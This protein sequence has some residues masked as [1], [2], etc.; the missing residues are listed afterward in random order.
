[1]KKRLLSILLCL[2]TVV[3]LL[4]TAAFAAGNTIAPAANTL[5]ALRDAFSKAQSGDTVQLTGDITSSSDSFNYIVINKAVT[6]DFAGFTIHFNAVG[7]GAS[8]LSGL[9]YLNNGGS[10]TLKGP[11]GAILSGNYSEFVQANTG[12]KLTVE[13]GTYSSVATTNGDL[14]IAYGAAVEIKGGALSSKSYYTLG[15]GDGSI[16][17]SGGT[18]TADGTYALVSNGTSLTMTGGTISSNADLTAYV[19]S[20]GSINMTG[21]TISNTGS[22]VA[23]AIQDTAK[24]STLSG[25][26]ITAASGFGIYSASKLT[27]ADG[28]VIT[29]VSGG[30]LRSDGTLT[31]TGGS[32]SSD[33]GIALVNGGSMSMAGGTVHSGSN[34][35]LLNAS[36]AGKSATITGGSLTSDTGIVALNYA[37]G[38]LNISGGSIATTGGDCAVLNYAAG[39]VNITGGTLA[40][41]NATI[42]NNDAGT[43]KFSAGTIESIVNFNESGNIVVDGGSIKTIQ[44]ATPKNSAGTALRQYPIQI[45]GKPSTPIADG[46]LS[47]TPAVTYGFSGVTTDSNSMIYLWLPQGETSA[48]YKT[49]SEAA[50]S[51]GLSGAGYTTVLPNFTASVTVYLD[52]EVWT[53]T[54]S[55]ILLSESP[56][57]GFGFG[58]SKAILPDGNMITSG[59]CTFSGLDESKTY[60]VWA[61]D[62]IGYSCVGTTGANVLT[63]GNLSVRVDYYSITLAKGAGITATDVPF[64][65][66]RKGSSGPITAALEDGYSFKNWLNTGTS[67]VFSPDKDTQ[68]SNISAPVSLTAVGE[69]NVYDGAVT[70]KK[71]NAEWSDSGKTIVLSPSSSD[72]AAEGAR[73]VTASSATVSFTALDPRVTYYVWVDGVLTDQTITSHATATTLDYYTVTVAIGTNIASVTINGSGDSLTVLKGGSAT[74]DAVAAADK[75]FSRWQTDDGAL[76][77]TTAATTISNITAPISLTAVGAV[78]KYNATVTVNLDG[79]NNWT[80]QSKIP[81]KLVLSTSAAECGA[82]SGA[83]DAATGKYAFSKLS[84]SGV[85]YLWDADTLQLVSATPITDTA[86]TVTVDYYTVTVTNHDTTNITAVTGGGVYLKGSSATVTATPVQ[87]YRALW[88]GVATG[89]NTY[90]ISN[91]SAAKTIVVTAEKAM[92]TGVITLKLDAGSPYA[93][94]TVTLKAGADAPVATTEASGVYSSVSQ[95][96]PAKAYQVLVG[97]VD[98]GTTLTGSVSSATVQYYTVS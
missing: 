37:D 69:L 29:S 5:E 68:V 50:L 17:I 96:D 66:L 24:A 20:S 9:F 85:Y 86:N 16:N 38:A 1:M 95:L 42:I 22:G 88:D 79:G 43:V 48:V 55:S 61:P 53:S 27:V 28:A 6:L 33:S 63:T 12:S 77:S 32:I 87:Y 65:P 4:P 21:G 35:S 39:T 59:V 51:G 23:L 13:S 44:G 8:A 52:N 2:C 41:K 80:A 26:K 25:G 58:P 64:T 81:H 94:Q 75:I 10:L 34:N 71:N 60:Y 18:V 31:I 92:Y 93:G 62:I 56:T 82:I 46:E 30:G 97:G 90:E 84:G 19:A 76:Y 15:F 91:V 49:G 98:T 45:T 70:V 54:T 73:T 47:F 74:I 14:I 3:S 36:P 83:F 57:S 11:G 40:A 89:L 67:S 78:D 7:T 72:A